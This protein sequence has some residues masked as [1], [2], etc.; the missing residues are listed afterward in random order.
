MAFINTDKFKLA[1]NLATMLYNVA[2]TAGTLDYLSSILESKLFL[3]IT[4]HEDYPVEADGAVIKQ[5][6]GGS[7]ALK[8]WQALVTA[9]VATNTTA[10]SWSG[11][12][13]CEVTHVL[14]HRGSAES[15]NNSVPL[16]VIELDSPR[17]LTEGD[18]FSIPVGG[19]EI[20]FDIDEEL[21]E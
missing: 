13:S 21:G 11:M 12:P 17:T 20:T 19:I 15:L 18:G 6:S 2:A 1:E 4:L 9:N 14:I 5:V 16:Q 8:P 3:L 7:Y 10:I